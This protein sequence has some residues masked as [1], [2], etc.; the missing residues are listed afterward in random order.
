MVLF[1]SGASAQLRAPVRIVVVGDSLTSG[2]MLQAGEDFGSVLQ[3]QLRTQQYDVNVINLSIPAIDTAG[4][5][6]QL[7]RVLEVQPDIA[8]IALGL[9]DAVRG[10]DI[11]TVIYRNLHV[12]RSA[13]QT[14]DIPYVICGVRAPSNSDARYAQMLASVYYNLAA[15]QRMPFVPDILQP[16][17]GKPE[18]TLADGVH[19]NAAGVRAMVAPVA[20]KLGRYVHWAAQK[21]ASPVPQPQR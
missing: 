3:R 19:P 15:T 7:S 18:Y 2:Y 12:V 1:A 14:R 5:V 4:A 10:L 13:F 11:N 9:N 6:Q 20:A 17:R 16:L 8:I 21:K